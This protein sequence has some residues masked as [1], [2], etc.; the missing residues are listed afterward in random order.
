MAGK[1]LIFHII[2]IFGLNISTIK[3]CE[4]FIDF[5]E[6][7]DNVLKANQDN[8]TNNYNNVLSPYL[9]NIKQKKNCNHKKKTEK[10]FRTCFVGLNTH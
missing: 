9:G 5:Y 2:G 4:R 8:T 1:V 7:F 6:N 10:S 3:L